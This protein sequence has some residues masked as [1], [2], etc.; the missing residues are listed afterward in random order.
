MEDS[1]VPIDQIETHSDTYQLPNFQFRPLSIHIDSTPRPL[2]SPITT[3]KVTPEI[4]SPRPERPTSSQ[5][6]KRFSKILDIDH[7]HE[8]INCYASGSTFK[9][10]ERVE[11]A[12]PIK[13]PHENSPMTV[14]TSNRAGKGIMHSAGPPSSRERWSGVTSHDKSTVESLL[15]KH[16]ECLGLRSDHTAN[17]SLSLSKHDYDDTGVSLNA[18]LAAGPPSMIVSVG[19]Y[20]L[21]SID[22]HRPT[23]L[24]SSAQ[25]K[26]MPKRLFAS[27]TDHNVPRFPLRSSESDAR[28][29]LA[30]SD[31]KSR[32]SYGWMPLPSVS[33]I[34]L[35]EPQASKHSLLSGD[36][37]DVESG[38]TVKKFKIRRHSS[39]SLT[40]VSKL[41]DS[42]EDA[43]GSS[44]ESS[45]I[46][47]GT[48]DGYPRTSVLRNNSQK[49]R[50]MK[51][52]LKTRSPPAASSTSAE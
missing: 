31:D 9:R 11:E 41:K 43:L 22:Q 40:P 2:T 35:A 33:N 26:L 47:N 7:E 18:G 32:P 46:K 21:T 38:R 51:I 50:K 25:R 1:P 37:V 15:D 10:L 34:N 29:T 36:Y 5:S 20:R 14:S 6:R 19:D 28:F 24:S 17:S 39:P 16:I 30:W 48:P 49:H 4:I 45:T 27:G 44:P 8:I 52:H 42:L 23:S 3:V 12:S 13:T